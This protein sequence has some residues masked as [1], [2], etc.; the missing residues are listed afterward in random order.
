MMKSLRMHGIAMLLGLCALPGAAAA[1]NVEEIV[2]DTQRLAAEDGKVSLVWWIPLEFWVESMKAAPGLPAEA[3]TQIISAMADHTVVGLLRATPGPDGL[4]DLQS[5]AELAKNTRLEING[6]LL[7][8]LPP[9][10]VSPVVVGMLTQL[11]P[12]LAEAAGQVGEGLDFLIFPAKVDEKTVIDASKAGTLNIT[13][14][15]KPFV[16]RLPLASLSPTKT[17]KATGEA[18]PANYEF[19][20]FTG[21]KIDGQ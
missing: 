8:P 10:E 6:K 2:R 16:W 5:R 1:A 13:F 17:D 20:P 12:A 7:Q 11:K 18:F 21:K 3:S 4:V 15:G 14:Y 9:D 19:N